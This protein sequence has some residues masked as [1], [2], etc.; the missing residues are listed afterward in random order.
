V[1][2]YGVKVRLG[3]AAASKKKK[4]A[5]LR[6]VSASKFTVLTGGYKYRKTMAL[7]LLLVGSCFNTLEGTVSVPAEQAAAQTDPP[8]R[9]LLLLLELT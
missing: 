6:P 9:P 3:A 5:T 7:P 4:N 1:N 2:D 8:K